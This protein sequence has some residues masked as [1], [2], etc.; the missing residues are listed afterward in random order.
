MARWRFSL[1]SLAGVVALAAVSC[2]ALVNA[3]AWIASGFLTAVFLLLALATVRAA[4]RPRGFSTGFAIAGWLYV[5]VALGPFA[6]PL[7]QHLATTMALGKLAG[8]M[9]QSSRDV[10]VMALQAYAAGTPTPVFTN[11]ITPQ[12]TAVDLGITVSGG[13]FNYITTPPV[14]TRYQPVYR[15]VPQVSTEYIEAFLRIGQALW[16]MALAF[17]GGLVAMALAVRKAAAEPANPISS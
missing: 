13:A 10:Q 14:T 15:T 7:G 16:T 12:S 9:P 17:V 11:T 2:A 3:S 4:M 1:A 5:A 8:L 6:G